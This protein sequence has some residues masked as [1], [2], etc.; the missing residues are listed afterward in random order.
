METAQIALANFIP[1]MAGAFPG[2]APGH[3]LSGLVPPQTGEYRFPV[4]VLRDVLMFL[5]NA[6]GDGLFLSG[7]TGCGKTSVVLE[8]AAR[9]NWPVRRVNGHARLELHD[10]VGTMGLTP[11]NGG[12]ASTRFNHGPLALAMQE[13]S[14]FIL[15]EID[16]VDPAIAAGLNPILEGNPLVIAENG[17]E[18][19]HPH[20]NFRFV[21]T[22]NTAGMGDDSGAYAGT[23]TQNLAYLDRFW[24]VTVEYP[25]EA[26]ELEILNARF[27]DAIHQ[28]VKEGMVR[29]ANAVREQFIGSGSNA[30]TLSVTFSTRTLLR[31]GA[32]ILAYAR[33]P[34][35]GSKIQHALERALTMRAR[36]HEREAIHQIA[37]SVFGSHWSGV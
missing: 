35:P 33:S 8:T 30:A 29:A 24:I 10:L 21:A 22:G 25:D 18:I 26:V 5:A 36:P 12:G 4:S 19:I 9:L 31:W 11:V 15:D 17:G 7:P 16:L 1:G 2:F 34:V 37:L 23:V 20:P 13:G 27:G 3:N 28:S 32:L 6:G 14:I